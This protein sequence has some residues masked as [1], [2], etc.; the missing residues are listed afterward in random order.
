MSEKK[1]WQELKSLVAFDRALQTTEEQIAEHLSFV[2]NNEELEDLLD[3]SINA[4]KKDAREKKKVVD[5]EELAAK[6]LKEQEKHIKEAL[7]KTTN[8]K[9]FK[10]ITKE[11][12][13]IG[14]N[15]IEQEDRLIDAWN[16]LEQAEKK[17]NEEFASY[18]EKLKKVQASTKEHRDKSVAL[19]QELVTKEKER[20]ALTSQI[21]QEA[22]VQYNRMKNQVPDPI[23]PVTQN[24]CSSCFYN[25]L[26][27]DIARLRRSEMVHCMNCY[28][29]LYFD[30]ES[31]EQETPPQSTE[32]QSQP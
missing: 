10:A 26:K 21:P 8:N 7:D 19:Q 9:E 27:Q 4:F 2:A 14:S 16:K 23:V 29:F 5:S 32:N 24:T 22:L 28:R 18:E 17:F 13:A 3:K 12:R 20:T 15:I 11:L 6:E 30:D 31:T 1:I 25:I